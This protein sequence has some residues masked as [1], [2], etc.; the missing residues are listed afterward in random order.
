[1]EMLQLKYFVTVARLEHMTKA[2][3]GSIL[4]S[5]RSARPLPDLRRI[6]AL[7]Y[8]NA[9]AGRSASI[10]MAKHFWPKPKRPSLLLEDGV[11]SRIWRDWSMGVFIWPYQ[12]GATPRALKIVSKQTSEGQLS[13]HPVFDGGYGSDD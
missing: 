10:R 8:S 13:Y 5:R 11:K 12:H 2:A 9:K 1:M 6:L 4:L 3:E 7:R